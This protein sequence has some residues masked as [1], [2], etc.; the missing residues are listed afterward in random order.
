MVPRAVVFVTILTATI[1]TRWR[2]IN[3]STINERYPGLH[4]TT[5]KISV[6]IGRCPNK[7]L[8]IYGYYH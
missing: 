3:V 5:K 4:T 1:P 2:S 8:H 6:L 7:H